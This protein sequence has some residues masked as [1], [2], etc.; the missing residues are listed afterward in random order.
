MSH[1]AH[2]SDKNSLP[3]HP[4]DRQPS[5]LSGKKIRE[6]SH[7]ALLPFEGVQSQ[8]SLLFLSNSEKSSLLS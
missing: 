5:T 2:T 1:C 6:S 7:T 8:V 3:R 4:E